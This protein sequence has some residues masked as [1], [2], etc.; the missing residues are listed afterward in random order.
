[1]TL[2]RRVAYAIVPVLSLALAVPVAL[3]SPP[4]KPPPVRTR[5]L[6]RP[7]AEAAAP[8]RIER[9][10]YQADQQ[11]TR[12]IVLL[13]RSVPYEVR[14]LPGEASR[15]SERRVV[16]DFSNAKLGV[17]ATAPIG[18]EDGLLKQIRTGQ[19]TARTAR[20]VLDMASVTGHHVMTLDD[21]RASWSTSPAS[22]LRQGAKA[23]TTRPKPR[24]LPLLRSRRRAARMTARVPGLPPCRVVT[25]VRRKIWQRPRFHPLPLRPY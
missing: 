15:G 5:G 21:P 23:P 13:S 19:F 4:F 16:L 3:A 7:T 14:I 8:A 25:S 11:S 20:V 12:V 1:M 18:V 10:R 2:G 22:R 6:V 24:R 9:V 17:D